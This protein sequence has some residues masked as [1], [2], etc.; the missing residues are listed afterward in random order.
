MGLQQVQDNR[1]RHALL[2][3]L[4]LYSDRSQLERAIIVVFD[5]P[6]TYQP[7]GGMDRDDEVLPFQVH[8][9]DPDLVDQAPDGGEIRLGGGTEGE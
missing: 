6:T 2:A 1:P 4:R 7:V 5:L 3:P 8:R 9:V